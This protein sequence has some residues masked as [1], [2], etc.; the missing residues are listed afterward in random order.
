M[1]KKNAGLWSKEYSNKGIPSSFRDTPSEAVKRFVDFVRK[2]G[3]KEGTAVD[4]GCGTGRNSIY[5]AR[6]GFDVHGMDIV[7]EMTVALTKKAEE[8]KLSDRIHAHCSSVSERWP[9]DDASVDIAIDTFCYTH[10]V[11][12]ADRATYTEELA[13]ALKPKGLYLLTVPGTDD[14]YYG[15]FMKT[16]PNPR[17]RVIV[18]KGNGIPMVL[19]DRGDVEK[20]F[21]G[22]KVLEYVHK[23]HTNA[24]HGNLYDRSTHLFI[25]QK[26]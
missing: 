5:L 14:G 12:K 25:F 17:E 16:S 22:F 1:D 7:P 15:P 8:L 3:I 18:D 9:L 13:R 11:A 21:A 20:E 19:Y 24:M 26:G 4:I 23:A 10:Q 2:N 6:C